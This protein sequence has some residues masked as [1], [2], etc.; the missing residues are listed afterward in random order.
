MET[1]LST[2]PK[3]LFN[4]DDRTRGENYIIHSFNVARPLF[5]VIKNIVHTVQHTT[6]AVAQLI[7]K[8]QILNIRIDMKL[9]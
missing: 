4:Y 3:S 2:T 1:E 8:P 5:T 7:P 9:N 6:F